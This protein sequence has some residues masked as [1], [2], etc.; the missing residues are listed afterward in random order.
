MD[1]LGN[2]LKATVGIDQFNDGHCPNQKEQDSGNFGKMRPQMFI[3]PMQVYSRK[4]VT[5]PAQHSGNHSRS[6]FVDAHIVLKGDQN[7]A[8]DENE[9]ADKFHFLSLALK[10]SMTQKITFRFFEREVN[11]SALLL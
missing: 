8:D 4:A 11:F 6:C 7:V 5:S 10:L 2:D 1:D 3:Q 9:N